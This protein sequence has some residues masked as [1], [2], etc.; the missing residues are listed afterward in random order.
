MES[1][2]VV[3]YPV[4]WVAY[5]LAEN[6]Y[7]PRVFI[8]CGKQYGSLVR[9]R[10]PRRLLVHKLLAKEFMATPVALLAFFGAVVTAS[11]SAAQVCGSV[12]AHYAGS[13]L[14]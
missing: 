1:R 2:R 6:P 12:V 3:G 8:I 9:G 13:V 5:T 4:V 7:H 10:G 14:L 11:A